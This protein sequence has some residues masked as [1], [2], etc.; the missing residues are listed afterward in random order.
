MKATFLVLRVSYHYYV[1]QYS[2]NRN[3]DFDYLSA[4]AEELL[5]FEMADLVRQFLH[6]DDILNNEPQAGFQLFVAR[7]ALLHLVKQMHFR[8][9]L[10]DFS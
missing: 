1:K 9:E 3:L 7:L 8:L 10:L 5:E 2:I 4:F 6:H